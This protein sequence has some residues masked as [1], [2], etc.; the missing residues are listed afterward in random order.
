MNYVLGFLRKWL[1]LACI[2]VL[3]SRLSRETEEGHDKSSSGFAVSGP[4]FEQAISFTPRRVRK[5][6]GVGP[7]AD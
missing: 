3:I 1:W 2:K 5:S 6:R 7:N 4:R